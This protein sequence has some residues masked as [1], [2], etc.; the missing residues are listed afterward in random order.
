[1]SINI[2]GYSGLPL[3]SR[4]R[5]A[6]QLKFSNSL[7]PKVKVKVDNPLKGARRVKSL[8]SLFIRNNQKGSL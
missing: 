1:M 4:L 5:A 7:E 6:S 8:Q 2:K 3:Y